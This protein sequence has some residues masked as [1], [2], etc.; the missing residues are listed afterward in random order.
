M[1]FESILQIILLGSSIGLGG[2]IFSKIPVVRNLPEKSRSSSGKEQDFS[3]KLKTGIKRFNPLKGLTYEFLLE[4]ALTGIRTVSSNVESKTSG[5]IKELKQNIEE[6]K[7]REK[8]NYWVKIKKLTKNKRN[9]KS[10]DIDN[11]V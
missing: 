9:S 7:A 2:I 10:G 11:L 1:K 8:D 6:R 4:K 5:L 3:L